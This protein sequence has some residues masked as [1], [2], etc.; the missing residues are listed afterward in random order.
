MFFAETPKMTYFQN[1]RLKL[2]FVCAESTYP[3]SRN[4]S[5]I[6]TCRYLAKE[7]FYPGFTTL[8]L[9]RIGIE[10]D[11]LRSLIFMVNRIQKCSQTSGLWI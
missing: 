5:R 8:I 4:H 10:I 7:I 2:V 3:T 9:L 11:L 1:V 6:P